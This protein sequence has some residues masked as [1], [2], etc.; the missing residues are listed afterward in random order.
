MAR[1]R[2]TPG[3]LILV[4]A[5]M[6]LHGLRAGKMAWVDPSE[7]WIADALKYR[8]LVEE[9]PLPTETPPEPPEE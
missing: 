4:R 3:D 6:N 5:T 8:R 9:T 1:K 2:K 7:D